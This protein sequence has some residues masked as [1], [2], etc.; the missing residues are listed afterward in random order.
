[1]EVT[2]NTEELNQAVQIVERI[3]STRTTLPIIGNILF[4]SSKG[5]LKLS[6]NNLEMGVEVKIA[7]KTA[8]TG[9]ILIPAKTLGGIVSKLPK[10]EVSFKLGDRGI[11]KISYNESNF[12]IHGLPADEFPALPKV[13]GG[14]DFDI[15]A[16]SL[17]NMI[18]KTIFAVSNSEDKYVLNGVLME[19]GKNNGDT[20]SI[21]MIATDGYR[22]AKI[23]AS[24]EIKEGLSHPVIIPA[25][26]LAELS[27]VSIE[28]EDK[29]KVL[30][31]S[32]QIAFEHNN[33]YLVSRLIQGQFPDYNQV[34]PKKSEIKT[35]IPLDQ[36]LEAAERTAVIAGGSANVVKIEISGKKVHLIANTP[37]VGSVDEVIS[38]E[39][40]GGE[41]AQIAFNVRLIIDALKA[42]DAEKVSL[43]LSGPL[44]PGV[45]RP[46]GKEDYLYIAMP[47]RTQDTAA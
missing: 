19:I 4:E 24:V 3:V 39:V 37:D 21:R 20:S 8:K 11:I 6:A 9:S 7:A 45:I 2:L 17:F 42:M 1:M 15:D 29:I 23:A 28:K 16:E 41:K 40:S 31:S 46:I 47:I 27:K 25:R 36:F 14:K 12:N 35:L 22:L 30:V 26:A 10:G 44:S 34:I 32:E 43:E 18:R 38:A 13:K 5:E 33:I